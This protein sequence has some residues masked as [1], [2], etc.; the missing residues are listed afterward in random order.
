MASVTSSPRLGLGAAS[1]WVTG[2]ARLELSA[3]I[4]TA[5]AKQAER[6]PPVVWEC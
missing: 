6:A 1:Q 5:E 3:P 2:S 4:R